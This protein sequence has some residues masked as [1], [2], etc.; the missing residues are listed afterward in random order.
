MYAE[1]AKKICK[2]FCNMQNS[3][4]VDFAYYAYVCTPHSGFAD[5]H[6][7]HIIC[8]IIFGICKIICKPEYC[9]VFM[10]MDRNYIYF[11]EI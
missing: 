2:A 4:T 1:Y 8:N 11:L 7:L 3:D 10:L 5:V 6:I 9:N